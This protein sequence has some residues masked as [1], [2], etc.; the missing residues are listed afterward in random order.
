MLHRLQAVGC[1]SVP[2][3]VMASGLA[4]F[5]CQFNKRTD[6]VAYSVRVRRIVIVGGPGNGKSTLAG[7]IADQLGLAHIELDS[8]FHRPGWESVSPDEFRLQLRDAID[9]AVH[10]WVICGNYD[11]VSQDIHL[12]LA[13]TLIWLDLPRVTVTWRTARR[14][15]RRAVRRERLFGQ[16]IREPLGNF[17]RWDPN[18]NIIRWAWVYHPSYAV[19]GSRFFSEPE[20]AHLDAHHLRTPGAVADFL[21]GVANDAR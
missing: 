7:R 16:E 5:R 6:W 12:R 1:H 17:L 14:T 8:L 13:D 10:G 20:W 4:A 2:V 19:K 11:S 15:I 21:A 18:K 9:A 3:G